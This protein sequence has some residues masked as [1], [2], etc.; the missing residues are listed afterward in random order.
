[1]NSLNRVWVM[2]STWLVPPSKRDDKG[3]GIVEYAAILILV[4]AIAVAVFALG[5]P[6]QIRGAIDSAITRTLTGPPE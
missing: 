6:D 4:A 5:I 3:A 1:M 2:L